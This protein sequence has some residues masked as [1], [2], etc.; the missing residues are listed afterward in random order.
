M[1]WMKWIMITDVLMMIDLLKKIILSAV[2]KSL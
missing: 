1:F 2:I